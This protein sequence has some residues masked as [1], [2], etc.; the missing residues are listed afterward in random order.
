MIDRRHGK[1]TATAS[2]DC[3]LCETTGVASPSSSPSSS[4]SPGFAFC[5]DEPACLP[6]EAAWCG[7]ECPSTTF[8]G[9]MDDQATSTAT[10]ALLQ[11][12]DQVEDCAQCGTTDLAT[13]KTMAEAQGAH[14]I[15]AD[16]C[17][18]D[19]ASTAV[20]WP[21]VTSSLTALS[22]TNGVAHAA[23]TCTE[24]CFNLPGLVGSAGPSAALDD[25]PDCLPLPPIAPSRSSG[26]SVDCSDASSSAV[27]TP[28]DGIGSITTSSKELNEMMK[29]LDDKTIQEIVR[30][31]MLRRAITRHVLIVF[32]FT[33][34]LLLLRPRASAKSYRLESA[35][36][37]E[38]PVVAGP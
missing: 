32:A 2:L 35:A 34:Q 1:A 19:T 6:V 5:C 31:L 15:P 3:D 9:W 21:A 33:A 20:A 30:L 24:A 38:S 8:V 18:C 7:P 23:S 16:P 29:G 12:Q 13:T 10:A 37:C 22:M 25:C 36:T 11:R 26:Q 14:T 17:C 4:S 28:I 27:A